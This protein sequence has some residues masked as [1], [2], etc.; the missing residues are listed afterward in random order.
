LER[1]LRRHDR[2]R[3]TNWR[4]AVTVTLVGGTLAAAALVIPV[5]TAPSAQARPIQ[6]RTHRLSLGSASAPRDGARAVRGRPAGVPLDA[7]SELIARQKAA[8]RKAPRQTTTSDQGAIRTV[9]I[10]QDATDLFRAVGVSWAADPAVGTVSVAVRVRPVGGPWSSW[11]TVASDEAAATGAGAPAGAR[12]GGDLVWTGPATAVEVAVTCL[13]GT[14][15]GDVTIDLIDPLKVAADSSPA[16][17]V[18]SGTAHAG[19]AMPTVHS[20]ASWGADERRMSWPPSYAPRIKAIT[21]HHT[22]TANGYAASDVPGILRSIYQFQAISRGWGDVGYNVLV[23]RFGRMWEGRTGGLTRP[24]IGAHAGGFNSGTAGI[25]MIGDYTSKAVEPAVRESVARFAAWKLSLYRVDPMGSARLTGGPSTKYPANTTVTVPVIF[26]H[27]RTSLT[28]CPGAGGLAALP[29]IR[30]RAAALMGAWRYTSTITTVPT[31]YRPSTHQWWVKGRR[32]V[33]WGASG[34]IPVIGDY[35]GN[36]TPEL[37]L[38]RPST[39]IWYPWAQR[40]IHWGAP[41][42]V[43]LPADWNGDGRTDPAVFRPSTN[44]WWLY[45]GQRSVT[46]GQT[47]DIPVPADYDGDGTTDIAV[48]RPSNGT[49]YLKDGRSFPI[50]QP[51]DVPVPGDYDGDGTASVAVWRSSEGRW[52]VAGSTGWWTWGKTGDVLVPGRYDGSGRDAMVVYRPSTGQWW[53]YGR[54]LLFTWGARGD[55][56]QPLY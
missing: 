8:R 45:A 10:R 17:S 51:G 20:R 43:P 46:F 2:T 48:Y 19:L 40:P 32:P 1:W 7:D 4:R 34:D 13:D 53:M 56:P 12:A 55:I 49:F 30:G 22:A 27:Q 38:Y 14:P 21:L 29:G 6:P 44:T 15:P 33:T 11:Q 35:D 50:G 47:G 9:S 25:S 5:F 37:A 52:Y 23:D 28:G 31:V 54:G 36:T 41:G 18:P 16:G 3:A 42:D 24:V 39:G 26:P